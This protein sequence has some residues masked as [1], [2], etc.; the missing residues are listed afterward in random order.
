MLVGLGSF[1]SYSHPRTRPGYGC[2]VQMSRPQVAPQLPSSGPANLLRNPVACRFGTAKL[3]QEPLRLHHGL[4]PLLGRRHH[5]L[6]TQAQM[7]WSNSSTVSSPT[8]NPHAPLH[9]LHRSYIAKSS[10]SNSNASTAKC[11]QPQPA[12]LTNAAVMCAPLVGQSGRLECMSLL[13]ATCRHCAD[14]LAS[15]QPIPLR[16]IG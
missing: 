6:T 12:H 2:M 14:A 15:A 11:G 4:R 7:G 3:L 5:C 1:F 9:R 13:Q 16:S 8:T 10:P